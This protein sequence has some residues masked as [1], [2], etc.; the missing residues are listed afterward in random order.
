MKKRSAKSVLKIEILSLFPGMFIGPL[1][2]SLLAKAQEKNLIQFAIHNLRDFTK[3]RHRKVDDRQF[4]GGSGMLIKVEPIY[5]ALK[6]LGRVL[7][8]KKSRPWVVYMSPQGKKLDQSM[9]I[10]LSRKKNLV[11][12]CGHYE[13]IDE[14]A[15]KWIDQE[16]SVGDV[17]LTGGEIPAMV[18]ADAV[19]RLVPGVVKEWSSIQNDSFFDGQ[20]DCSHYTRPPEFMG[21]KVPPVLLSGN[22]KEVEAWRRR[23]AE[24]NT[25]AKRPDL[26]SKN[27]YTEISKEVLAS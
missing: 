25:R 2:E 17:V 16:I 15:M 1:S 21:M 12:I 14:R 13:G 7:S 24:E 8:K 3:D 18:L 10:E 26:L 9:A 19:C 11:L 20:L 27:L 6:K 23:S 4:G 5:N 22:H